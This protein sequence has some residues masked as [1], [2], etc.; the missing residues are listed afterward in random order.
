MLFHLVSGGC[1]F[2]GR[3]MVKRLYQKNEGTIL[4]VDNLLVGKHPCE[5]LELPLVET[6]SNLEVY[7]SERRLLFL[8]IDFR[9]FI[10]QMLVNP[11]FLHQKYDL[12]ILGFHDIYHFAAYV[13]GRMAIEN[14]PLSI[15][16][17]LSIDADFFYWISRQAPKRVL[18]PSSS[19]AYPIDLQKE[20]TATSLKEEDI[21]F[22][23]LRE[24][25]LLYGWTKL[26]GEY[27]AKL[28][29]AHYGISIACVRPFSGYGEDQDLNY[30]IP[31]IVNRFVKK[32]DPLMVWGSGK[33]ARDFVYID[34]VLDAM[35]LAIANITDGSAV[36]IGTGKATSFL[37]IIS[38]LS[39]IAGY[40]PDIKTSPGKPVG[41][42]SRFGQPDFAGE[43]LG[44]RAKVSLNEGL[45]RVYDFV[46]RLNGE[47]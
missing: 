44:W 24:P 3:N 43:K 16:Q 19:A 41:V 36:N 15:A 22:R 20:R 17:D 28:A 11:S 40:Q 1:G 30:P 31:A 38:I 4:F 46:N 29:A 42:F 7:G 21:D 47:N 35:E 2:I 12:P 25:D 39:T 33:Q 23:Q 13:G 5:W 10:S 27:L 34:D 18:Y 26:T 14:D 6:K 9:D 32:E 37:D 45:Q 8:Q